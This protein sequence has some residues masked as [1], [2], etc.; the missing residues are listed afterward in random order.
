MRLT[1]EELLPADG[2]RPSATAS[3]R[4]RLCI[5]PAL[6]AALGVGGCRL[7]SDR[8]GPEIVEVRN[9][10]AD[11]REKVCV[12]LFESAWTHV[13]TLQKLRKKWPDNEAAL[14]ATSH[15]KMSLIGDA[16]QEPLRQEYDRALGHLNAIDRAMSARGCPFPDLQK[17]TSN[18][19]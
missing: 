8:T 11:A 16:S 14:S 2:H 10:P 5:C 13:V 6:I 17:H 7:V 15:L 3:R 4:F 9:T 19:P 1:C 12:A 18:N